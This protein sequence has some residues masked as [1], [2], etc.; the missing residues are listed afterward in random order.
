MDALRWKAIATL[1]GHWQIRWSF[2][3]RGVSENWVYHICVKFDS[4]TCDSSAGL[5]SPTASSRNP[6]VRSMDS[7]DFHLEI[8][9]NPLEKCGNPVAHR[10]SGEEKAL[11]R[12]MLLVAELLVFLGENR[13][14]SSHFSS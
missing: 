5:G 14:I 4:E 2:Y 7:V 10:S 6:N 8:P 11:S 12:S 3:Y 1:S 9:G 13:C